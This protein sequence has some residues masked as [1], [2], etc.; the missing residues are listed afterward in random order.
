AF[1]DA[2]VLIGAAVLGFYVDGTAFVDMH[3]GL[4]VFGGL[5]TCLA[6]VTAMMFLVILEKLTRQAVELGH[7]DRTP[8]REVTRLK[9]G[10]S[11]CLAVG[12]LALILAVGTGATVMWWKPELHLVHQFAVWVALIVNFAAFYVEHHKIIEGVRHRDRA[13]DEFN[14]RTK[15]A[16]P[17]T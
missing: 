8:W 15:N 14:R 11:V 2:V 13:F 3:I 9:T 6:H 10:A 1:A 4:A 17:P 16:A 5:V 12:V 7:L